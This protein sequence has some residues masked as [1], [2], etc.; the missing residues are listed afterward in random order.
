[1]T[2][3]VVVPSLSELRAI[4][5]AA[6]RWLRPAAWPGTGY[7]TDPD[8]ELL[9]I[10]ADPFD[11]VDGTHQR[12]VEAE[13]HLR[14]RS[15]R[16]SVFLTVYAAMTDR[17]HAGIEA[18]KFENP[19]WVRSYLIDFAN[20]YRRA[21]R[22]FERGD[23]VPLPWEIGFQASMGDAT[24]L[25]QDALL[26]INAH[27]NFDLP[28]S[29]RDVSID[30][31][32]ATKHRDHDTI[33]EVL[34]QLVDVI[35][36]SLVDVYEAEGYRYLDQGLGSFDEEFTLVGLTEARSLAWRNAARLVDTRSA[37]VRR[38]VN[39]RIRAVST[40]AA[41]FIL[42]PSTD[43]GV[44]QGLRAIEGDN[45]PITPLVE[46]FQQRLDAAPIDEL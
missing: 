30:P 14:A 35:Q 40:G 4:T 33:N 23:P 45:P 27:I 26:G 29:L 6:R 36:R 46:A 34:Q 32:R 11:S 28:Y 44:L 20:R 12:L 10:L 25:I 43:S 19:P 42:A 24:L 37:F 41:G 38:Y 31:D 16:R 9:A 18:G 22:D 3:D 17:V 2:G 39:W 5:L 13:S 15:D 8:E 7:P 21:L 1:M